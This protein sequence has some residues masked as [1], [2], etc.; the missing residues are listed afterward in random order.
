MLS[1]VQ[2]TS[3]SAFNINNE[4]LFLLQLISFSIIFYAAEMYIGVLRIFD[5]Y[6]LQAKV[7]IGVACARLVLF[8]FTYFFNPSL[9]SFVYATVFSAMIGLGVKSIV[10]YSVM[11]SKTASTFSSNGYI[12]KKWKI[13]FSFIFYNNLDVTVRMITRQVDVLVLG[14]LFSVDVA[15]AYK[16][17]VHIG[18]IFGKLAQPIFQVFYPELTKLFS[19]NKTILA[20]EFTVKIC[21]YLFVF[22][23]SCYIFYFIFGKYMISNVFGESYESTYY[24]GLLYLASV[25]VAVVVTPM[26]SIIMAK[27][28]VKM[29]FYNQVIVT[30]LFLIIFG[31]TVYQLGA[32]SA[33]IAHIVFN[34]AW[35]CLAFYTIK[36]HKVFSNG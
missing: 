12:F 15:G 35:A 34:L 29:A 24:I 16:L 17:A 23:L 19:Q 8:I 1:L 5:E 4:Y 22:M 9:E 6:M 13:L 30:L 36:R 11:K 10:A 20:K 33:G 31:L 27:G 7:L 18:S 14:R 2:S 28:L 26:S 32:Y 25:V 21:S 3:L